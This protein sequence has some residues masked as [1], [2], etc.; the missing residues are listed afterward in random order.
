MKTR[1]F[2]DFGNNFVKKLFFA[3][4][5]GLTVYP[6]R[7]VVTICTSADTGIGTSVN[8]DAGTDTGTGT[9]IGTSIGISIGASAG[10][11]MFSSSF[12]LLSSIGKLW[13]IG[14]SY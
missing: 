1:V 8:T 14:K 7:K 6:A 2:I 11:I 4:V 9:A 10:I 12:L 5:V 3:F 13:K